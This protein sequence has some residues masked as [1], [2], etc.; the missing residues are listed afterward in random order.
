MLNPL[1]QAFQ[2]VFGASPARFFNSPAASGRQ[3]ICNFCYVQRI[4]KRGVIDVWFPSDIHKKIAER[5]TANDPTILTEFGVEW[6]AIREFSLIKEAEFEEDFD[7]ERIKKAMR[8]SI[9]WRGQDGYRVTVVMLGNYTHLDT[10]DELRIHDERMQEEI[11]KLIHI[12]Y[13]DKES[14]LISEQTNNAIQS[15]QWNSADALPH[16]ITTLTSMGMTGRGSARS[17]KCSGAVTQ[18]LKLIEQLPKSHIVHD[19][20]VGLTIPD[21]D[22]KHRR[23]KKVDGYEKFGAFRQ[24]IAN[25]MEPLG[26]TSMSDLHGVGDKSTPKYSSTN[27]KM[28]GFRDL[29]AGNDI[30]NIEAAR[31]YVL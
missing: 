16:I 25:I 13:L 8:D 26:H 12:L 27:L 9:K 24:L 11:T 2:Q 6:A 31:R 15:D 7:P 18:I 10:Y 20:A 1:K 23:E 19:V 30:A 3:I 5:L 21:H 28:R 4:G 17:K 14:E 22:S 29:R